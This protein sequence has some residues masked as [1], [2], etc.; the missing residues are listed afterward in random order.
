MNIENFKKMVGERINIA[1]SMREVSQP[2][3]EPQIDPS[4]PVLQGGHPIIQ[5]KEPVPTVKPQVVLSEPVLQ[6]EVKPRQRRQSKKIRKMIRRRN[7]RTKPISVRL[8]KENFAFLYGKCRSEV[9][10]D[11]LSKER[12]KVQTR[13]NEL[14]YWKDVLEGREELRL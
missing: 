14:G 13:E 12:T 4:E 10:N 9:I 6:P 2:E 7:S 3:P 1:E 11:L 5:G 8:L